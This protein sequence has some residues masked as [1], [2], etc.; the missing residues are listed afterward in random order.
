MTICTKNKLIKNF[1]VITASVLLVT[2]CGGGDE[3]NPEIISVEGPATTIKKP[4]LIQFDPSRYSYVE[5]AGKQLLSVSRTGGS[6]GVAMYKVSVSGGTATQG[7]DFIIDL[8]NVSWANGEQGIKTISTTIIN[9]PVANEG[10]ENFTVQLSLVSG[11][12]TLVQDSATVTITDITSVAG[13]L[14]FSAPTFTVLEDSGNNGA[15]VTV[16]RLN[17]TSGSVSVDYTTANG[18][19]LDGS[20]YRISSGTLTWADGSDE[21]KNIFIDILSDNDSTEGDE[22]LTLTLSAASGASLGSIASTTLTIYDVVGTNTTT[23]DSYLFYDA[24]DDIDPAGLS[25]A[26]YAV[27]PSNPGTPQFVTGSNN[28]FSTRILNYNY[29]KIGGTVNQQQTY[30][31]VYVDAGVLMRTAG[32]LADGPINL[33]NT[34]QISNEGGIGSSCEILVL[35]YTTDREQQRIFYST[36]QFCGVWNY[37]ELGRPNTIPPTLAKEPITEFENVNGNVTGYLAIDTTTGFRNLVS[38][39]SDFTTCSKIIKS[40]I[41]TVSEINIAENGSVL[42]E[43]DDELYWYNE[44]TGLSSVIHTPSPLNFFNFYYN[45]DNTNQ[46]FVDGATIYKL[47]LDGIS[48]PEVLVTETGVTQLSLQ[49]FFGGTVDDVIYS[50][51]DVSGNSELRLI[52]KDGSDNG[53]PKILTTASNARYFVFG[54]R[55]SRIYYNVY[56]S[57]ITIATRSG[58]IMADGSSK[59]ESNNS[60]WS[61]GFS[62]GTFHPSDILADTIIRVNAASD[63]I[64]YDAAAFTAGIKL[65]TVE[66]GRSTFNIG[67][68]S[69]YGLGSSFD[70]TTQ[71][72]PIAESD[73]YFADVK[74]ANS[75]IRLTNTTTVH[76]VPTL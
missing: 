12:A 66:A 55:N 46:Y 39:N 23:P 14:Q 35:G 21:A 15:V 73:V 27:D 13:E 29:H 18:T 64:V 72:F 74:T 61:G 49:F 68:A 69:R 5:T 38:C 20:D 67:G 25:K 54:V 70:P 11:T 65:G 2:S 75:L 58:M 10:T 33:Q 63:V 53:V 62:N 32:L 76:E 71:L 28:A 36:G 19:A 51:T 43:I 56:P 44:T 3:A 26:I 45:S 7:Q 9:N 60:A 59:R 37:V 8:G 31:F 4:G 6:D 16:S 57:D 42:L 34:T 41:I 22:T 50:I 24:Q 17:G 47:K 48:S 52:A 40:N 1:L 30:A